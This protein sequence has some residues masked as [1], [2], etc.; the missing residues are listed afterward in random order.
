MHGSDCRA[1]LNCEGVFV[2]LHFPKI[3]EDR[4]NLLLAD[5]DLPNASIENH[6]P[7]GRFLLKGNRV[8]RSGSADNVLNRRL[9]PRAHFLRKEMGAARK[10]VPKGSDNLADRNSPIVLLV[11]KA[12]VPPENYSFSTGY[13]HPSD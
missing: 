11:P 6:S 9:G 7:V 10:D 12:A 2:L 5:P 3:H 13:S 8:S 4:K 1:A